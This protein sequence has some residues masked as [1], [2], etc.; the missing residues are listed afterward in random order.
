MRAR[1]VWVWASLVAGC[2]EAAPAAGTEGGEDTSTSASVSSTSSGG[3]EQRPSPCG[4]LV[5]PPAFDVGT[6]EICFEPLVD[7]QVVAHIT[8]PQGGYHVWAAAVCPA[9][10]REVIVTTTARFADTGELVAEP[11][12]RVVEL[13]GGQVAGLIAYLTG[14]TADPASHLPKGTKLVIDVA[15]TSLEGTPLHE[16]S[17]RVELG[18]LEVWLNQCDPDPATCGHPG[19]KKCC[20]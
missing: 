1:W 19:G 8:G 6:G 17:K 13:K 9:C 16:G 3:D 11:G 4:E 2:D 12:T 5:D 18:E 10:P 15:L 20:D 7:G 14:S